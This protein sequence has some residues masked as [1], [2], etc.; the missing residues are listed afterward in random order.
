M[1]KKNKDTKPEFHSPA[2][3]TQPWFQGRK[4]R[5]EKQKGKSASEV[6]DEVDNKINATTDT[7]DAN[8][9]DFGAAGVL[10][11]LAGALKAKVGSN[12]F[13]K[14]N[15]KEAI[16]NLKEGM[17]DSLGHR[18]S[19]VE[20]GKS[21]D[22]E[23]SEMMQQN[24]KA[25]QEVFEGGDS[26]KALDTV[27]NNSR[28]EAQIGPRFEEDIKY[29]LQ[30]DT[31]LSEKEVDKAIEDFIKEHADDASL[32]TLIEAKDPVA[33]YSHSLGVQDITYKLAKEQFGLSDKEAKRLADAAL[34]HDIG[35][36]QVPDSI[37]N[38][39]FDK[40]KYP[41]LFKWMQDHDFVGAEILRSDPFSA[42]IAK[43]HH[44]KTRK[45]SHGTLEEGAVTVADLYEA[46]TS[47]KRSYKKGQPKETAFK[48]ASEDLAGGGVSQDYIGFLKALDEDGLLPDNYDFPSKLESP[49]RSMKANEI[50]KQ[51]EKD[52]KDDFFNKN[53][54][55]DLGANEAVALSTMSA[56]RTPDKGGV[57]SSSVPSPSEILAEI[58]PR[59][60][61]TEEMLKDIKRWYSQGR[62]NEKID[63]MIVK[64]DFKNNKQVAKLWKL[65]QE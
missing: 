9:I 59:F 15:A 40:K 52:Y 42:D 12:V 3:I 1:E 21:Y 16:E 46:I 60:K 64:T 10:G 30:K 32:I 18:K 36:I 35:K 25:A 5:L 27:I 8:T 4:Q 43:T 54:G 53:I 31:G 11:A 7:F 24:K 41:E 37:I 65:M 61:P 51:V 45:N 17:D 38:S 39:N 44:P 62:S 33:T 6:L 23:V 28:R 56:I 48:W 58:S 19:I 22:K 13:G 63:K 2:F 55:K 49:Y 26:K 57:S 14:R 47:Q 34:V 50:K 20:K 29:I